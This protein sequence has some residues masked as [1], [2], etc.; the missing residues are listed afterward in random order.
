MNS[1]NLKLDLHL[2]H[3]VDNHWDSLTRKIVKPKG[4]EPP[5]NTV[6]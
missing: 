1:E 3:P 2:N 6:S 4:V 5:Q